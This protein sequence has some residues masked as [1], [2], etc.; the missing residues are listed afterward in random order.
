MENVWILVADSARARILSAADPRMIS[1][2][3]D[4]AHPQSRQHDQDLTSDQPGR[5]FDSA[6]QGRHAMEPPQSAHEAEAEAFAAELAQALEQG[7]TAQRFQ[8]LV[9]IAPPAFLGRIRDHLSKPAA[10]MVAA[11]V[12]KNLVHLSPEE[13][14]PYVTAK[15]EF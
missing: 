1:E 3:A 12:D 10:Q 8:R 15:I 11:Q 5:S 4:Y 14:L 13:L 9:L 7:R 6:G 2:V